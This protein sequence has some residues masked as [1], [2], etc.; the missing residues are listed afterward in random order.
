MSLSMSIGA[1]YEGL[2]AFSGP[3]DNFGLYL[4]VPYC[5]AVCH[6]CDFAKTANFGPEH[7]T[8][9]IGRLGEHLR[10]WLDVLGKGG[11]VRPFTSVFFGGGTPSLYTEEYA[12]LLDH[13]KSRSVPGAEI[14]LEANPDDVTLERVKI[15]R[16]L[17]INRLSLGVQ[18]FDPRGLEYLKRAHDADAARMAVATA[19]SVF[20][21]VNLDLI[22]GWGGQEVDG[23]GRDLDEAIGLGVTH[24]SLY[25]LT[26]EPRT[27]IGRAVARGL[28]VPAPDERLAAMYELAR[29]RLA[30]A[31]FAHEEVSNWARP[32]HACRHNWGYWQDQPYLGIGAG[33]HGYLKFDD[34]VGTR[35]S[36]PRSDRTFL[37]QEM[38]RDLGR[39]PD[40]A[41]AFGIEVELDRTAEAW[42]TDYVGSALRTRRGLSLDLIRAVA[43]RRFRP[44][45]LLN[46]G[47]AKGIIHIRKDPSLGETLTLDPAEWFRE[48]AWAVELLLAFDEQS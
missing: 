42:V 10:G 16:S 47:L 8:R 18:T 43:D 29:G 12:R 35:Y 21:S 24:L 34:G 9:Y 31:G 45:R 14:T 32:G 15:W 41:T 28:R 20:D 23:F 13:I 25:T 6:Y 17:G 30:A 40:L 1:C 22:Y 26:Y 7:G 2:M 5:K 36:Y 3:P 33:A 46:E 39:S 27:P 11:P 38:A 44:T 19:L 48:T 4:H 37:R